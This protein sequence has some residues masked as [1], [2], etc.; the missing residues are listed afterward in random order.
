MSEPGSPIAWNPI[1]DFKIIR[2]KT[3]KSISF[4]HTAKGTTSPAGNNI[5][6]AYF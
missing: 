3:K 2:L 5:I 6:P 1:S 4:S